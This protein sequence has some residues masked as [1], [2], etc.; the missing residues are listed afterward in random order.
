MTANA[1]VWESDRCPNCQQQN[2]IELLE[3][4]RLCLACREDWVPAET[5]GPYPDARAVAVADVAAPVFQVPDMP[6]ELV[7]A[8]EVAKARDRFVGETVLYWEENVE[9]VV[10]EVA[11]DGYCKVDFG[12]LELD[13]LPDEFSLVVDDDAIDSAVMTAIGAVQLQI[14]AL[15]I[16]AAI[17]TFVER[18]SGR[19]LGWPP[20]GWLQVGADIPPVVE[21]GAAYAVAALALQ[22]GYTNDQLSSVAEMLEEA[23]AAAKEATQS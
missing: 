2:S 20:E 11:D 1:P 16:R 10:L 9:G 3:G 6:P 13:L 7:L 5:S 14:A 18:D 23:A 12:G 22:A 17:E 19:Q 21:H 4:H 8:A 15:T